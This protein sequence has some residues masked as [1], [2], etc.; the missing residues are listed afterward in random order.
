MGA[1][2][3]AYG[4]RHRRVLLFGVLLPG[5]LSGL[6]GGMVRDVLLGL[7]PAAVG[8]WCCI[9]AVL[10]AAI[11]GGSIAYQVRSRRLP[12]VIA[13]AIATGQ[14]IGIG[15]QKAV[16]YD[17]PAPAV[18]LLSVIT[19][20][21]GGPWTTR[22]PTYLEAAADQAAFARFLSRNVVSGAFVRRQLQR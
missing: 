19:A 7:E 14:L 4:A 21:F 22:L 3:G 15:V 12:F 20:T 17:A 6:G 9:P 10:A 18:M 2:F 8:N 5:A 16:A 11:V 1:L 13:Q